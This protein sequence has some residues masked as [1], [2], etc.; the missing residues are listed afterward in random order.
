MHAKHITSLFQTLVKLLSIAFWDD[1]TS[2]KFLVHNVLHR[3]VEAQH[4]VH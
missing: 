1:L 3:A 2:T 4:T